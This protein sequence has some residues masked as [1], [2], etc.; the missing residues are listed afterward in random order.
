MRNIGVTQLGIGRNRRSGVTRH[1]NFR[2][3]GN[4][5]LRRMRHHLPQIG[6]SIKT[7]VR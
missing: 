3:D 2:H 4:V 5:Q 1:L 6:L 7:T